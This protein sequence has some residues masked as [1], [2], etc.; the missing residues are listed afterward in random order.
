[1]FI[2]YT[3]YRDEKRTESYQFL[4]LDTKPKGY[5]PY[6]DEKRTESRSHHHRDR[7]RRVT[8]P[9]AMKSGLKA[10]ER[11][12]VREGNSEQVTLPTAMKSGL[13]DPLDDAERWWAISGR[14]Y[15]PYRDEK[16]TERATAYPFV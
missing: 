7:M 4:V 8:L 13:K 12:K 5:T 11:R 3:P 14:C 16:R 10:T 1:M 9:T 15:T 6:R 2:R